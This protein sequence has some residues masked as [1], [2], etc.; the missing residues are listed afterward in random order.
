MPTVRRGA[1]LLDVVLLALCVTTLGVT[2]LYPVARL[3]LSAWQVGTLSA[4]TQGVGFRAVVNT[5]VISLLSVVT[6]AIVGISLAFLLNRYAFPGR[7][8]LAGIA[9]LPFSLPPLVGVLSF[10]Y[11]IG[12]DGFIPRIAH[13][14][15]GIEHAEPNGPIGILLIHTYSFYVFFYAMVSAA[16]EGMDP[17]LA[18]AS[19]TLGASRMRTLFK[20]TLPTLAPAITGAALLTFMSSGASFSAPYFFGGD[21][22]VL[23]TQIFME[24]SQFRTAEEVSLTVALAAI[25]LLGIGLFR[26]QASTRGGASKGARAARLSGTRRWIA[27]SAA[28]V[29]VLLLITPHLTILWLSFVDHRAWHT[30]IVP[31]V[32]TLENYSRLFSDATMFRPIVNSVWMSAVA[33]LATLVIGLP[34]GYLIGRGRP[35]GAFMNMM[36]MIPWALPGTV[37][38]INL[39]VAFNDRWVPQAVITALLPI[40]Y[41][42]RS[43]PMFSRM[44][45]AAFQ[46][47]DASLVEAGRSLGASPRYCFVH[48]VLP[49]MAPAIVSALAMVFATCLGEFVASILLYSHWNLPISVKINE[50]WRGIGIGAAFAYSVFMMAL[51]SAAF[52]FS[53]RSAS[54]TI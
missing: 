17:S 14:A 53:R 20:V 34:C 45:T 25:A 8:L 52:I 35:G 40:A 38:A 5:I 33:G 36:V 49:L 46:T 21:Y 10:W 43:I 9:F 27:G 44:A 30:E 13:A 12:P 51:V 42:V 7:K 11:I 2:V 28:L 23:S 15:F 6:S 39:L 47:F 32:F 16:L 29:T 48:V 22:P 24:R 31:T 3:A 37:V 50:Q 26:V 4:V 41:F 19:R 18:E 1:S 54:R